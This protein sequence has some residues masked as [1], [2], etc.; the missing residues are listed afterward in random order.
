MKNWIKVERA[1]H[2]MSQ[3]DLADILGIR[4][5]TVCAME[6]G[7]YTPSAL[8]ILK[9][10]KIFNV[11]VEDIFFLEDHELESIKKK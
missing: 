9:I 7:K 3:Q 10:A 2:D 11:R 1:R 5:Q 6:R 4:R 8:Y